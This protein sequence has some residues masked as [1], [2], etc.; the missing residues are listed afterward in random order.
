MKNNFVQF[1]TNMPAKILRLGINLC[2]SSLQFRVCAYLMEK[3]QLI[4][5]NTSLI[6]T[7]IIYIYYQNDTLNCKVRQTFVDLNLF[8]W[9]SHVQEHPCSSKSEKTRFAFFNEIKLS[10][11]SSICTRIYLQ[12]VKSVSIGGT[13][14]FSFRRTDFIKDV[15]HRNLFLSFNSLD[16]IRLLLLFIFYLLDYYYFIC[17]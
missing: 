12:A 13:W 8:I 7:I 17:K 15:F 10:G 6:I 9:Q 1:H 4:Y 2:H 11:T 3:H 5:Y 16:V 14:Q